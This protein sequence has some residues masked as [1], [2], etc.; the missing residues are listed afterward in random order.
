MSRFQHVFI[1]FHFSDEGEGEEE[2][3][4]AADFPPII[5]LSPGY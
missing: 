4:A 5:P 3:A 1:M 2:V